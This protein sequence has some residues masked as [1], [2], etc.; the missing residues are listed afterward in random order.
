MKYA[1]TILDLIGNTPLVKLNRVVEGIQATVLVKVEYLNP[2][3]SAKDRIATALDRD[4]RGEVIR[5]KAG[6]PPATYFSGGKIQW[7][8]ENVDGV[9][10]AAERGDAAFG[11]TD[12]WLIWNLTGG[13]AGGVHVTFERGAPRTFDLVV[14]AD[15]IHSG[16][17]RLAFGPEERFVRHLGYHYALVELP[18]GVTTGAKLRLRGKGVPSEQGRAGDQLVTVVVEI[19]G[20]ASPKHRGR[21]W[22]RGVARVWGEGALGAPALVPL[23]GAA[24]LMCAAPS[25]LPLFI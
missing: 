2:G 3:G 9:R 18:A 22:R 5:R 12:T 14:G 8:L 10:E 11:N 20:S 19:F 23:G 17:R 7:I 21:I 24:G 16:I 6:L 1:D 15:G 13:T 4:G 25:P